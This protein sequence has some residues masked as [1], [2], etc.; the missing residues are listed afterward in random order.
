MALQLALAVFM[1]DIVGV[2]GAFLRSLSHGHYRVNRSSKQ[3]AVL[4]GETGS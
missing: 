4:T 1:S 3:M 2:A